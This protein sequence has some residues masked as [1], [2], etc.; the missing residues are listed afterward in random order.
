MLESARAFDL[1]TRHPGFLDGLQLSLLG[2]PCQGYSAPV[3]SR[4][5]FTFPPVVTADL[6]R[7]VVMLNYGLITH[8]A[9][10]RQFQDCPEVYVSKPDA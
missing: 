2:F 5:G 9:L 6:P 7:P 4:Y 10:R 3:R 1:C 8:A